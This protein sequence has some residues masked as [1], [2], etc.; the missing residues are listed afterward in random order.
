[1]LVTERRVEFDF[2]I[3]HGLLEPNRPN[4]NPQ[5][6]RIAGIDRTRYGIRRLGY[7]DTGKRLN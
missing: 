2:G 1:V 5:A 4:P 3:W 7:G 6:P